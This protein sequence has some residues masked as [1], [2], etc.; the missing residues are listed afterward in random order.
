VM[1]VLTGLG[2][3]GEDER[4]GPTCRTGD[5]VTHSGAT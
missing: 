5:L 3:A 4:R 2:L 1:A